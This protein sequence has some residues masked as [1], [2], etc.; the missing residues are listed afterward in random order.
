[1]ES[2]VGSFAVGVRV[3]DAINQEQASFHAEL[4]LLT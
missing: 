4:S 3:I 1:M 2:I